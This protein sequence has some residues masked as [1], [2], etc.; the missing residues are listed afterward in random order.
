MALTWIMW[1]W[2]FWNMQIFIYMTCCNAALYSRR[3]PHFIFDSIN[4]ITARSFRWPHTA[5]NET[6]RSDQ[7]LSSWIVYT[8]MLPEAREPDMRDS[9]ETGSWI[10]W[11]IFRTEN[12]VP[13]RIVH[14]S[15]TMGRKKPAYKD[16]RR[17]FQ[18]HGKNCPLFLN[19]SRN[20]YLT[21]SCPCAS[22][23]CRLRS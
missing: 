15:H 11:K 18:A 10:V 12:R 1:I 20:R 17:L 5:V 7:N 8:I 19:T 14:P 13:G 6:V 2:N 23:R 21:N 22:G 4:T 3:K 9:P 16:A